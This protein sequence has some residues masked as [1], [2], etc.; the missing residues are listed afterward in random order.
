[1]Q[2]ALELRV[3]RQI[4]K[5]STSFFVVPTRFGNRSCRFELIASDKA[6]PNATPI[7]AWLVEH[8]ELLKLSGEV[9]RCMVA[10]AEAA[11]EHAHWMVIERK[12]WEID[13]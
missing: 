4:E 10:M 11:C 12:T 2:L 3:G 1:V 8:A 13:Q 9:E 7:Y 5:A 6:D